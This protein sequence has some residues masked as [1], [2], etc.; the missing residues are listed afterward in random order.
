[1]L[2][3]SF[4]IKGLLTKSWLYE[5]LGRSTILD[6][7]NTIRF[8]SS[9]LIFFGLSVLYEPES[10]ISA[11]AAR[12]DLRENFIL[13]L[14]RVRRRVGYAFGGGGFLL[15]DEV[16]PDLARPHFSNLWLRLLE[17]VGKPVLTRQPHLRLMKKENEWADSYL[18]D[19][20]N[21]V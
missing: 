7:K 6:G 3:L 11:F 15:T 8:L 21:K 17:H 18:K 13:W 20:A 9:G 10:S 14:A 12:A 16:T 5:F 1:M 2:Y 4:A 19:S